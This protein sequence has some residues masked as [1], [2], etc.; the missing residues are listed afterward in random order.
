MEYSTLQNQNF[1]HEDYFFSFIEDESVSYKCLIPN[2]NPVYYFQCL[3]LFS[4]LKHWKLKPTI[5]Q[6]YKYI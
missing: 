3:L 4:I 6:K 1:V 2:I 5:Y